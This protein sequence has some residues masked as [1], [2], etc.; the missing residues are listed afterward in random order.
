MKTPNFANLSLSV[1]RP[2]TKAQS[3]ANPEL[4]LTPTINKFSLNPLA[5]KLMGLKDGDGITILTND[6]AENINEMYFL[7]VGHT[8][9]QAKLAAVKKQ[10]GIG[11]TLNFAYAG[12]YSKMLQGTTDAVEVTPQGM[13]DMGLVEQRITKS[14][15]KSYVSLKKVYA[16]VGEGFELDIDGSEVVAYPLT[17][18]RYE[19]YD[20]REMAGE[21][22]EGI[23]EE[24]D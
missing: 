17:D 20:P 7:A 5:T 21:E 15:N 11:R 2:G 24:N 19:D 8:A 9:D 18:L 14:D 13:V 16:I 22:V 12:V 4:T 23:E 10:Q 3:S 6:N 1:A